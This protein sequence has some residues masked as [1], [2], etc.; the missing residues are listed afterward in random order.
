MRELRALEEAQPELVTPD[1][2]TQRAGSDLA[3]EFGKV[4]HS[5]PV[6]SLANAFD[7][8]DLRAWEQRNLRLLPEGDLIGLHAR[9]QAGR[10][11]HRPDL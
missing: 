3:E 5:A 11:Q 6:L 1:S 10:P 2:P 8:E 7:E 4:P 9:A